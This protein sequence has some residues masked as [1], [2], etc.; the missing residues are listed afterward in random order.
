MV[1]GRY[2]IDPADVEEFGMVCMD[3]DKPFAVGDVYMERAD[4]TFTS[5][6]QTVFIIC[7]GCGALEASHA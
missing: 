4:G 3:C 2:P 1:T 5:G 6:A 7:V